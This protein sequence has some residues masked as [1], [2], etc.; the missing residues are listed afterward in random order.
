MAETGIVEVRCE[1]CE[2]SFAPEWKVCVHCGGPLGRSGI[3]G[4]L[5]GGGQEMT[6]DEDGTVQQHTYEVD[7]DVEEA[8]AQGTSRNMVWLFTAGAMMLLSAL[9]NCGAG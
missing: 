4:A 7:P 6:V 9:R 5:R 1:R 2:T 8:E 3:F